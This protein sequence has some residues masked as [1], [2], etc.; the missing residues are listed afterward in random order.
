VSPGE[1]NSRAAALGGRTVR[2]AGPAN[3]TLATPAQRLVAAILGEVLGRPVTSPDDDFFALGGH[4]L[5]ATRVLA[6]LR[7]ARGVTVRLRDL[8]AAPTVAGP[9]DLVSAAAPAGVPAVTGSEARP[10]ADTGTFPLTRVQHAYWVGRTGTYELGEVGCHFFLEHECRDLDL[11]RY[12][13]AWNLVIERHEMLRTVIVDGQNQVLPEVPRYRIP[14]TDLSAAGDAEAARRLGELRD[15]LSHR[16]AA[17][18][19]W[20]LVEVHAVKL[21]GGSHHVLLFVDVLVC[22]S[23]SYQIVDREIRRLYL[24][25][26]D[27]L[28]PVGTTFETYVRGLAGRRR[29]PDHQRAAAYWRQRAATLPD[30]P[31]L[32]ARDSGGPV[33][34][35]RRREVLPAGYWQRLRDHAAG[36][37]VTPTALL[38]TAYADVLAQWS[39]REH[40]SL[41]LTVFDRP[42][43]PPGLDRVIGE[44]SSLSLLEVDQRAAAPFADR[45]RAVQERL[46]ADLDHR[47]FSGLELL[48]ERA[49]ST[50]RQWNV[51]V[52][53]TG[54]L[55]LDRLGDDAEP[56]DYEWLGPV[57]HGVSQTPQVWL[58]HQV[59]EQLG[60]L[61]LQWDVNESVLDG[62]AADTAFAAYTR[63]LRD[64]ADTPEL[65]TDQKAVPRVSEPAGEPGASEE[66]A[67][68]QELA[69]IWAELL[70]LEPDGVP[71]DASFLSLGGDSLLAVRMAALV[72]QRLGVVLGL[73]DVRPTLTLREL[74]GV[75]GRGTTWSPCPAR[76]TSPRPRRPACPR[77][78]CR[79]RR[80]PARPP[81]RRSGP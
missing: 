49:T 79:R 12:E 11:D 18:D 43:V 44:F 30:A 46:F 3:G 16:V 73:P 41:T 9:A 57:V 54:M 66:R 72:R 37:G 17:P 13:H 50:G 10:A 7:D 42:P 8:L 81:A 71:G 15:R 20:P 58:D 1:L 63:W 38:L 47:E 31:A 68:G 69:R 55:G 67:A 56:H 29:D 64:L 48:S 19:R 76:R 70:D 34:F 27:G 77:R 33:R 32:T 62:A 26:D 75:V 61:V 39:G 2:A 28:P 51:P 36:L 52:V 22:D 35:A 21:P 25:P 78:P 65:W 80:G 53:F 24:D 5:L 14:V 23:A 6:R 74:A 40:F 45:A 59:Y 60:G 4:S